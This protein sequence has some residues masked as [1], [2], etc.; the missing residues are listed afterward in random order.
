MHYH[1]RPLVYRVKPNFKTKTKKKD[2]YT[3][4]WSY[5]AVLNGKRYI[6]GQAMLRDM[7]VVSGR[8][9][10][11]EAGAT[12]PVVMPDDGR[13]GWWDAP[14]V[15]TSTPAGDVNASAQGVR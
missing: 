15:A 5:T 13:L 7:A 8:Q 9:N 4:I 14:A 6:F 2:T 1:N 11:V 10:A 12:N 3:M